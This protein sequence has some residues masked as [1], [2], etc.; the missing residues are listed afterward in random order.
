MLY[1]FNGADQ[2]PDDFIQTCSFFL[3]KWR[4]EKMLSFRFAAD[5]KQCAI[6]YLML[7]YALKKEFVF[8]TLPEFSYNAF[9][10]PFL[11]NYHGIYFNLSHCHEA[12]VCIL[13][14]SEVGVDFEKDSEYD[15]ELALAICSE[16]EYH[17]LSGFTD[18]GLKAKKFTELWTRKESLVKWRGTGLICDPREIPTAGSMEI[19]G[20]SFHISSFYD[21]VGDFYISV[22]RPGN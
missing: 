15:D 2:L 21:R 22:C 19:P 1:V 9:G 14:G 6:A 10:K 16:N 17:W 5:R 4:L 8:I 20:E 11:S 3:P 18:P 7:V 13:S 12:V